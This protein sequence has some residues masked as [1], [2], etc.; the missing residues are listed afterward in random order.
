MVLPLWDTNPFKHRVLPYV[1]FTLIA[2]NV[3][4]F[5]VET[6]STD[7][8][9]RAM[10]ATYG[11]TPAALV[12]DAGVS[13][14]VPPYLTLFTSLFV[15]ADFMHLL[16][17]MIFLFVFGDDIEEALGWLRFIAFYLACG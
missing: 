1:T 12:R 14:A 15:H 9:M 16:G 10:I 7:E 5:L 4:V 6:G 8:G 2:A 3:L 17:N 13:A 11:V